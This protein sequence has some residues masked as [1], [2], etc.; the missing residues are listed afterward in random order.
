MQAL[1]FLLYCGGISGLLVSGAWAVRL[2]RS[3]GGGKLPSSSAPTRV[4]DEP[5]PAEHDLVGRLQAFQT[6]RY[7]PIISRRQVEHVPSPGEPDGPRV[8]P[9]LRAVPPRTRPYSTPRQPTPTRP[10]QEPAK[11]VQLPVKMPKPDDTTKK[12]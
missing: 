5:T 4:G 9:P 2:V 8:V 6:Q 3:P 7:A 12:D 11:V 10:K 1:D